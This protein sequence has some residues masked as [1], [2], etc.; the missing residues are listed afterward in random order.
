MFPEIFHCIQYG[1]ACHHFGFHNSKTQRSQPLHIFCFAVGKFFS[2]R[3][4]QRKGKKLHISF[5]SNF[6][7]QLTHSTAAKVSGVFVC[8]SFSQFLIDSLELRI[9]NNPFA[10]EHQFAVKSNLQRQIGKHT[11]IMGYIFADF[12]ITSGDCL[13]QFPAAVFQH[14]GQAIQFPR[15]NTFFAPQKALEF[16]GVFCFIQ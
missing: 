2:L 1:I 15:Q 7:V 5:C 9:G 14:N 6:A 8:F 16:Q 3:T 12:P 10:S 11:G 4:Y 13:H